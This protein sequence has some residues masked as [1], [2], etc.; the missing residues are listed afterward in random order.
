MKKILSIFA[1]CLLCAACKE[2]TEGDV[3]FRLQGAWLLRHVEYPMCTGNDYST[4][5][6]GTFCLIYEG[7]SVLY[8][9]RLAATPT[10]LVVVPLAKTL[11]TLIDNGRGEFLYFE[12]GDP[13][14]LQMDSAL[15]IQRNGIRYSYEHA[16]SLYREWGAELR[17][18]MRR[19]LAEPTTK[20]ASRYV[21]SAK[22]RQQEQ[23]LQRYFYFSV[24]IILVAL[25]M[26]HLAFSSRRARRR[27]QLQIQQI[28]EVQAN[29][30]AAVR[31]AFVT[32]EN[33][34]FA[35]DAYAALQK[36][37]ASGQRMKEEEWTD[38]EQQLMTLYPGFTSQLRGLYPMSELELQV[39]QLIKL[40]IPPKDIA[41]V[42]SRDTSTISTVRS[43]LYKKVFGRK[44]STKEWDDFIL[45]IGT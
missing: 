25:F 33:A 27:L 12:D 29:R 21:L 35:S 8:E 28:Q 14:P 44:G 43:R 30:S 45:T 18:I 20:E 38:V 37:M 5:G 17:D 3:P 36:R 19:D 42:L 40:R 39:C 2:T 9:C 34:Y 23:S 16:D 11:V 26:A 4:D 22:E 7:D 13:H 31:Q 41:A 32:E 15:T 6:N 1:L 24:V 10:G